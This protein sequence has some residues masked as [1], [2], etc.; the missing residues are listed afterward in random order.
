MILK[1][2]FWFFE[3][4]LSK[5]MCEQIKKFAL[6][7]R[8]QQLGLTGGK[9]ENSKKITKKKKEELFKI[10]NSNVVWL[11]DEWLYLMLHP[12]MHTANQNAGWNFHW[13]HSESIQFTIYKEKQFY[14]W[15]T[16]MG[17]ETQFNRKL[18]MSVQLDDPKDYEGGDLLFDIRDQI[19]DNHPSR[20]VNQPELRQQ[21]TIIVFPS[22]VYHKVTPV[23]KGTRHSLVMWSYGDAFK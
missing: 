17:L 18:S 22:F 4:A 8:E 2:Y 11:R 9:Q 7:K 6:N 15:H 13:T 10:R 20:I 21:G 1:D 3:K 12:Y 5:D 14:T 16:D 23:T 19:G